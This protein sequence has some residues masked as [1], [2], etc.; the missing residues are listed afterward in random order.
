MVNKAKKTKTTKEVKNG[1]GEV[2][3]WYGEMI[4]RDGSYQRDLIL[5]NILRLLSIHPGERVLDLACGSGFFSREMTKIGAEVSGVDISAGLIEEAKRRSVGGQEKYFKVPADNLSVF[6]DGIFDKSVIILAIQDV[7][8]APGAFREVARV[9]KSEGTFCLV[10]N[11]PVFRIPGRSRWENDEESGVQYRRVDE[12]MSESRIK[13]K[14]HPGEEKSA[15]TVHYHRPLQFYF[16]FLEKAGFCVLRLEEW[17]SE[18]KSEPGPRAIA[19]NKARREFPLFMAIIAKKFQYPL[20]DK[21][22]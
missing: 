17:V 10:I 12:Y 1:W 9:L 18:K 8:N 15:F 19:E 11:H 21:K 22:I 5:P 3:G 4:E 6:S 20:I 7:E 16:K 2:A 14:V 13:I